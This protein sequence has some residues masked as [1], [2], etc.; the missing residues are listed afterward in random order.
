MPLVHD[1][2]LLYIQTR[3]RILFLTFIYEIIHVLLILIIWIYLTT[4][5]NWN[6]NNLQEKSTLKILND[7]TIQN[8][9]LQQQSTTI[10]LPELNHNEKPYEK[11]RIFQSE[12]YYHNRPKNWSLPLNQQSSMMAKF[13]KNDDIIIRS[14]SYSINQTNTEIQYRN[15][16]RK[17]L[18]NLKNSQQEA[19]AVFLRNNTPPIPPIKKFT[20]E[21]VEAARLR[22]QQMII[23]QQQ[24]H[25]TALLISQ[26]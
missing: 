17:S 8:P 19:K 26:V 24:R 20:K 5:L 18:S 9:S 21:Q 11:I 6:I 25:S 22:A 4:K 13:D 23:Q 1:I 15:A 14:P 7:F 2:F 16:I 3:I 10:S 12:I